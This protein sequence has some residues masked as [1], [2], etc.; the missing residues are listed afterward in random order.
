MTSPTW[1]P[2]GPP[3][4]NAP[5]P[6]S[7]P[8]APWHAPSTWGTPAPA[9]PAAT[10]AGTRWADA[11]LLAVA[12]AFVAGVAWWAVVAFTERQFVYGAIGV[13][14]PVG[15]ATATGAR[16]RRVGPAAIAAGCT[17]VSLVIAEYFIQRTLAVND[18]VT[19]VPLW[20]GFGWFRDVV[21]AGVEEYPLTV[22][23]W[24][25]GAGAAALTSFRR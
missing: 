1:P 16:R 14:A 17:L 24:V 2:T 5:G 13:G 8:G 20:D 19:N 15:W 21:D 11:L 22:V 12:A 4:P 6:R 25:V 10:A 23:F 9:R 3:P 7:G 18:G